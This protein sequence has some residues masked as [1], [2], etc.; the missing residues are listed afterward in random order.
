MPS[1][2]VVRLAPREHA[3]LNPDATVYIINAGDAD[4][5]GFGLSELGKKQAARLGIHIQSAELQFDLV[6]CPNDP[7]TAQTAKK[8]LAHCLR[9]TP[10]PKYSGCEFINPRNEATTRAL[11][12]LVELAKA[13]RSIHLPQ[14]EGWPATLY[15]RCTYELRN[16]PN[17]FLE[18][19]KDEIRR[20]TRALPAIGSVQRIAFFSR[21]VVGN[22]VAE[23]LFPQYKTEIEKIDLGPG[24]ILRLSAAGCQHFPL[25]Y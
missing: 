13:N 4:G 11:R 15:G 9:A 16:T 14:K 5:R 12:D 2:N 6:V 1:Q 22:I 19:F 23:A 8:A 21:E 18:G 20:D 10:W 7:L 25:L 24:G 17:S 3:V